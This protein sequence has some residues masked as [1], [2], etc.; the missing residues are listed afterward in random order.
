MAKTNKT[1][2]VPVKAFSIQETWR[3]RHPDKTKNGASMMRH[4]TYYTTNYTAVIIT[5]Q[6]VVSKTEPTYR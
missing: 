5:L 6:S 4:S 3:T 1:A 2:L